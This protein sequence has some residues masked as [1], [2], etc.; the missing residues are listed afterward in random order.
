[1]F[2]YAHFMLIEAMRQWQ[3]PCIPHPAFHISFPS[4]FS[5]SLLH[6]P[7]LVMSTVKNAP[8]KGGKSRTISQEEPKTFISICST[9]LVSVGVSSWEMWAWFTSRTEKLLKKWL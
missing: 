5:F 3:F 7:L 8:W 6:F 2:A 1:V 9:L 4:P